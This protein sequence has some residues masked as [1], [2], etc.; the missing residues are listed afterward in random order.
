[1]ISAIKIWNYNKII[2][3][4][5]SQSLEPYRGAAMI[6]ILADEANLVTPP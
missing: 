6:S 3:Y 5:S 1:M 4:E 2:Q